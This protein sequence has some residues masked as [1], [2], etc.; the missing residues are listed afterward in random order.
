[1]SGSIKSLQ[2][3]LDGLPPELALL[4]RRI[5]DGVP[6]EEKD[7]MARML[8]ILIEAERP[9]T[10]PEFCHA[11]DLSKTEADRSSTLLLPSQLQPLLANLYYE[12]L[13]PANCDCNIAWCTYDLKNGHHAITDNTPLFIGPPPPFGLAPSESTPAATCS[14]TGA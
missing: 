8:T 12:N 11:F 14:H 13:I 5:L 7:D 9:L 2:S 4:Y 10:V 6:I 3:C 1:M